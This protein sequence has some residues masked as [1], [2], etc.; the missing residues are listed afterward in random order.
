M[1]AT[2]Y[3][4]DITK[5]FRETR[6]QCEGALAQVPFARW[7][8]RLDPES[9]SLVTLVLHLSGNLKSRWSDFLTSDGEKADRDRD[10]EFEDA[11]LTQEALMAR[12]AEGWTILFDTLASLTEAD[13]D[14]SVTIRSQP[15]RVVEAINRQVAHYAYH[16]G[17]LVFLAKHLAGASWHTLSVPRHGS[18]ALNAAMAKKHGKG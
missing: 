16:A 10:A 1:Y 17:Q 5:R 4:S 13:L 8:E 6:A 15:H 9:N 14:R 11:A 3:L 12:W 2:A 18:Q 7:G